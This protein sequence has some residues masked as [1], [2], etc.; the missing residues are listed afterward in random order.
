M[1]H[2][3]PSGNRLADIKFK[4]KS[5]HLN[6]E[7]LLKFNLKLTYSNIFRFI[8]TYFIFIIFR[9]KKNV[10]LSEKISEYMTFTYYIYYTIHN[11]RLAN[12][13]FMFSYK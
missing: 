6:T 3:F 10:G 9:I 12:Q 2:W 11:S 1:G 5:I 13:F 8:N 4:Y 7:Y